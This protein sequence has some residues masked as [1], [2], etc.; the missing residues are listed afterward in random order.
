VRLANLRR[1]DL[2][3]GGMLSEPGNLSLEFP[4]GRRFDLLFA[5]EGTDLAALQD[6]A[7]AVARELGANEA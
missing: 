1:G 3:V 7:N 2:L 5:Y 4:G 6:E